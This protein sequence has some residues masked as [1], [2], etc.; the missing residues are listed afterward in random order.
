MGF[1]TRI[2][3]TLALLGA[4]CGRQRV[5]FVCLHLPTP[6]KPKTEKNK[7]MW[8]YNACF[9]L[10]CCDHKIT[11]WKSFQHFFHTCKTTSFLIFFS[12]SSVSSRPRCMNKCVSFPHITISVA[13][14][15]TFYK[16]FWK[17][18]SQN[19]KLLYKNIP[20]SKVIC[21]ACQNSY[22]SYL[23]FFLY[24]RQAFCLEK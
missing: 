12:L 18:K 19:S 20:I 21:A 22:I 24:S 23:I 15:I 3:L 4:S 7:L 2:P 8:V 9:S 14:S 10:S 11:S 5:L 16:L 1:L 6:H 13:D 17:Y